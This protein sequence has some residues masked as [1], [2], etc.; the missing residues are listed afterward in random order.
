MEVYY[1]YINGLKKHLCYIYGPLASTFENI[2]VQ[3][4]GNLLVRTV[5]GLA[6]G[7]TLYTRP[8]AT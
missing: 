4:L 8:E 2:N 1:C 7:G 6:K 3:L 5:L